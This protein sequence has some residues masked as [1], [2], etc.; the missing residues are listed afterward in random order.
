MPYN[1]ADT[2]AKCPPLQQ[3][4]TSA[5]GHFIPAGKYLKLNSQTPLG[6]EVEA[7]C[8]LSDKCVP[9]LFA[10]YEDGKKPLPD[11]AHRWTTTGGTV[12]IDSSPNTDFF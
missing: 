2:S 7:E 8:I 11:N 6:I 9:L 10:E 3:A 4:V 1:L 12:S 5:L